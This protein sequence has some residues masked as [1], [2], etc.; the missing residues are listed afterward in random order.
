MSWTIQIDGEKFMTQRKSRNNG[1]TLAAT[2]VAACLA[3][4]AALAAD[5]NSGA[6]GSSVVTATREAGVGP[7]NNT[8]AGSARYLIPDG[9]N[10]FIGWGTETEKWYY[11]EIEPGK[12]YVMEAMDPYAD[13]V[14]GSMAGMGIYE[15][16]GTTTP[17]SETQVNC[18]YSIS[19]GDGGG[20]EEI[21]PGILNYGPRCIVRTYF[22]TSATTLNKRSIFIKV[23][24]FGSNNA[25]QIR[26][27]E[28]TIYGRWTTN[29]YDFHV[30]AQN[31]TADAMCIYVLLFPN[32]GLTYSAGSFGNV[33]IYVGTLNVPAW[34][35]DKIV[36]PAGTTVGASND[37]RGTMRLQS[38]PSSPSFNTD[39][40]HVS[41]YAYNP[42][43]DKFL[44]FFP[45]KARNGTSGSF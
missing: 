28:S 23:S 37:L 7:S 24:H 30:E 8:S 14:A 44:Y 45:S 39:G 10:L 11:T 1:A 42:V 4:S 25:A 9:S 19:V 17:P 35:A 13:K 29:G 34:G 43:T 38:C 5:L 22:P 20:V 18:G 15:S 16:D 27:R 2:F 26:V 31:T 41:T 6:G 33:P 3:S 32:A 21:A 40:L 12:T 36:V